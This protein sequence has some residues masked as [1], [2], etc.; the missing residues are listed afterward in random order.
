[1]RQ[2]DKTKILTKTK[3]TK[4]MKKALFAILATVAMVACSNDEV[5]RQAAPEAISFDTFVEKAT[6][7]V[8]DPS[9]TLAKLQETDK[10]FGVYGFVTG[11]TENADT[12]TA[13]IFTNEHVTYSNSEWTYSSTQYWIDGA[14]YNFS[15]LAPYAGYNSQNVTATTS[16]VTLKFNNTDGNIDLL[17]AQVNNADHDSAVS[18][19]FRHILSKV[20]FTFEN[21]YDATNTKI[22]IN[23][24]KIANAIHQATV[25]LS[26]NT[27]VWTA[28][29]FTNLREFNFGAATY[30]DSGVAEPKTTGTYESY[31]EFLLIPFNYQDTNT[32][33]V[34]KLNITFNYDIVVNEVKIKNVPV[35]TGINVN[36]EPCKAYDFKAT[37]GHGEAIEFSA[38]V[39]DWDNDHDGEENTNGTDDEDNQVET[40]LPLQ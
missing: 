35:S 19:N 31:N 27:P 15:A 34:Q 36:L 16:G 21:A 18:F 17:Y 30:N 33:A 8:V 25:A 10:G 23:D 6:R 5:V 1:M 13:P 4:I 32:L 26:N 40:T 2:N 39:I 7:S 3:N 24:I 38:S 11:D 28:E 12:T 37:I 20:K 9:Q 29:D 22:Q 14:T